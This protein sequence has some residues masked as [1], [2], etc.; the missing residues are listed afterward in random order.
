MQRAP[1]FPVVT[2]VAE[3]SSPA[4]FLMGPTA[5]GKTALAVELVGRLPLD[6]ISVDSAMVYRGLD[7]GTAKP[8][9]DTLRA[10]PHR[11]LDIREPTEPYSAAEF[12]ADALREMAAITRRGRVPLLVGGTLLYFRALQHGLSSLPAANADVRERLARQAS[13]QGL[14]AMY[15]RLQAVDPVTAARLH[16]NDPQRILRAL[17]IHAISGV[18]MST[19]LERDSGTPLPYRLLKLTLMPMD[20]AELHRRIEQR[21]DAML[22]A[23][24]EAEVRRL[25]ACGELGPELPALRAVGYRQMWVG[26][27]QQA[28]PATIRSRIL[29]ATRQYARRQL[30]W[31]RGETDTEVYPAGEAGLAG[32]VAQRVQQWLGAG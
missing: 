19:W 30:T 22:A 5:S 28:D 20:R 29:A 27:Q 25:L 31:L 15:A 13:E 7:I 18:P 21:L 10:A 17:E 3:P 12:R 24:F 6:I 9:A 8:G 14:P 11:L 26:L 4:I 32:A 1:D 23:G 16:P 2:K